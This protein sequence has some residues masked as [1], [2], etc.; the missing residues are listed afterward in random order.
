MHTTAA[1]INLHIIA[2]LMLTW[3]NVDQQGT[4]A[5]QGQP[6]MCAGSLMAKVGRRAW[7]ERL[8]PEKVLGGLMW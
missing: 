4:Q 1:S 7:I 3:M 6:R 8:R 2:S 5:V